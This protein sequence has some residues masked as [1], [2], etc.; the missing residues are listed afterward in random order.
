M[1]V[2]Q[3]NRPM[4]DLRISVIDACNFR[5]NYCMP[6]HLFGKDFA[7]LPHKALL[8]FSEI[9]RLSK[10]FVRLGVRKIRLTGGEPLLRKHIEELI[11]ELAK[12][13][14]IEEIALTTNGYILAEK[15]QLLK[16]AGLSRLTV[17]LDAITPVKFQTMAGVDFPVERV[18]TGIATAIDVGFSPIK[19]NMVVRKGVNEEEV[20]N[21]IRYFDNQPVIVR[22]IEYMDVGASNGWKHTD[23]VDFTALIA[24]IHQEI[25]LIKLPAHHDSDVAL[26]YGF[27]NKQGEIGFVTSISRPFCRTCVRVRLSAEGT[28]YSCLFAHTGLDVRTLLREYDNDDE[29]QKILEDHWRG[30]NDRYS[31]LRFRQK[32]ENSLEAKVEMFRMGG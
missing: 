16:Q 24:S 9:V 28:L 26:R 13:D 15:A 12:I 27:Q 7:F 20:L 31:E 25:P 2:D 1:V 22:F 6:L 10:L 3:L 11:A 30:R 21:A 29:L 8:S 18:L 5:C 17:S 14:R 23:V 32:D 19:V 4:R